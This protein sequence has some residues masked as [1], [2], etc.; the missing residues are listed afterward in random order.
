[1]ALAARIRAALATV[2]VED[3]VLST[4][5]GWAIYPENGTTIEELLAYADAQ[6]R[7]NKFHSSAR[8]P[9]RFV[10]APSRHALSSGVGAH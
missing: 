1:V 9:E 6:L 7:E 5:I 4:S 3:R 10:R 2:V 8:Q